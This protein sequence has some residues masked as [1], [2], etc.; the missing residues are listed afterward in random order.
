MKM[1]YVCFFVEVID[2]DDFSLDETVRIFT[3]TLDPNRFRGFGAG[4]FTV[5]G[6]EPT[7]VDTSEKALWHYEKEDKT[8]PDIL[9]LD[10]QLKDG[11]STKLVEGI[12]KSKLIHEHERTAPVIIIHSDEWENP[13]IREKYVS[14]GVIRGVKKFDRDGLRKAI[15][16]AAS[17]IEERK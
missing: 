6:K 12:R 10:V 2:D 16:Q 9:I 3:E 14:L 4:K 7:R 1:R 5:M 11:L 15:F 13:E 17:E 8:F